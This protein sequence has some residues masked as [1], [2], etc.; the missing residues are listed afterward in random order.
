VGFQGPQA[1]LQALQVAGTRS[2]HT[3]PLGHAH[4]WGSGA[5]ACTPLCCAAPRPHSSPRPSTPVAAPPPQHRFKFKI[6][7]RV[8]QQ[9]A[10]IDCWQP[11]GCRPHRPLPSPLH[12]PAR[13]I[14][15]GAAVRVVGR[16]GAWRVRLLSTRQVVA[17]CPAAAWRC[18][19]VLAAPGR[20][21]SALASPPAVCVRCCGSISSG[22]GSCMRPRTHAALRW[23]MLPLRTTAAAQARHSS[24]TRSHSRHGSLH[25]TGSAGR[26]PA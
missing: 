20:H 17:A 1:L 13:C 23:C 25:P 2:C 5:A 26:V 16:G 15:C 24:R 4:W 12:P 18:C 9:H 7:Q 8:P 14:R 6:R 21:V 19:S 10:H 22:C 11:L 3:R